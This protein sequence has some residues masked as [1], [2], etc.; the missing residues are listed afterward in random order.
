M[1]NVPISGLVALAVA[2]ASG[3]LV[4][5]VD[6]SDTTQAP[7]GTTKKI[8]VATLFTSIAVT[9]SATIAGGTVVASSPALSV[10]QTWNN[11]GVA[12]AGVRV[13][14]TNTSSDAASRLLDLQVGGVSV[15]YATVDGGMTTQS[16]TTGAVSASSV[17]LTG[18]GATYAAGKFYVNA[19]NGLTVA[20]K[21]GSAND[22]VLLDATGNVALQMPVGTKNLETEGSLTVGKSATKNGLISGT[23]AVGTLSITASTALEVASTTGALLV[24]RMT[25]TQRDALT[26]TNGM[27]IYSTTSSNFQ[28]YMG[29]VWTA[30]A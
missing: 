15:A 11:A 12:F 30:F 29:G 21:T 16:L 10:T 27:I 7:T 23:L 24:P 26:A 13:N 1:A 2:P 4:A 6:V 17:L 25:N 19:T 8:T 22:Y 3:D 5:I 18:T 9:T 28:G 20:T 14:I